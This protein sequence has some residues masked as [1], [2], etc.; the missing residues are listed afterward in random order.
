LEGVVDVGVVL[1]YQEEES[2]GPSIIQT[3]KSKLKNTYTTLEDP[4]M[5]TI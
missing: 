4:L 1:H 3:G 5:S 2:G